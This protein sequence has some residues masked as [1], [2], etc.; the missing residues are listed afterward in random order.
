M[1]DFLWFGVGLLGVCWVGMVITGL[2]KEYS[3]V[4]KC[5]CRVEDAS[6]HG[7]TVIITDT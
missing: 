2:E 5:L 7:K 3:N 6:V 1:T 4:E